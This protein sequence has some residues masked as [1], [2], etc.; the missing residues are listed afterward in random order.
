MFLFVLWLTYI[1]IEEEKVVGEKEK[2]RE[3]N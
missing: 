2:K 1:L 3:N